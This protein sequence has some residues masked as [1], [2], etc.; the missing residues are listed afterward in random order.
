MSG[1]SSDARPLVVA[2]IGSG[3]RGLSVLERLAVRTAAEAER[4]PAG[5]VPR[6]VRIHLIDATEIGA[7]RVWRT[8]QDG[9]FTMNTVIS[10]V[11]M[12]SGGPD[13]GPARP[14]A[15]PSLGEWIERRARQGEEP[16]GP[17]D[18]ASRVRYGHYLAD[19]Y[20]T[21]VE[22]LPPH[23]RIVPVTGR[24][25]ALRT[26]TDSGYLLSLDTAPHLLEADRVVLA[27]GHPRNAPDAFEREM[28][29]FAARTPN[30]HY[31]CGDS[32]ADL[33]LDEATIPPGSAVGVRGLGLSFYDVMLSL[34]VGRGGTFRTENGELV[35]APSGREPEIVAGSRSGLPIPA[36][37]RNQKEPTYSHRSLFLTREALTAARAARAAGGG[38]GQL[39]F[40]EDVL[41]LLLREVEHVYYVTHVRTAQG[42]AAAEEF[43][44]SHADAVRRGDDR[45]PLLDAA[46]LGHVPPIDLN[47][48]ARPFADEE[49]DSP[50]A[51]RARLLDVMAEDLA[52]AALGTLDGPLKSALDVLRDI[53]NVVREAVDHGGLLPASHTGFFDRRF[54]PVNAL[55]SAGP[56]MV[57][58]EQLRALVR[59]G[60][61]TVVGPGTA[62]TSDARSGGYRVASAQVAGSARIVRALVDARIPTP[63]LPRDTSP[64]IRGLVAD[65]MA[66]PYV[67]EGPGDTSYTTG[68]MDVTASPFHVIDAA[69]EPQQD[70]YALG[71]P[72]EHTRWFTQVGS[73]RPGV[74]T[75][76]YR[77]ADAIAVDL[78]RPL[79]AG[80]R[81]GGQVLIPGQSTSGAV[82]AHGRRS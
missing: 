75:L 46:G 81:R 76:F 44:R 15:G 8:D 19:V 17:D 61:V 28:L 36:R 50:E 74:G 23:V 58:V 51:F 25:T 6:P 34:T 27:T 47:A 5:A 14:G 9:W 10:Q 54:L 59:Q 66:R 79:P 39:D 37:G 67:I 31:L 2:V 72:T 33:P 60:V 41:P 48:L 80:D 70:L 56:P 16:L 38:T 1:H 11:T 62:F 71:I 21:I 22:H 64:L 57:R 26:G 45:G 13:E 7:G 35:Y 20:R 68:G 49:F 65:G 53:R 40:A 78:L 4:L 69:G 55:L 82:A 29:D 52:Q 43:A 24:V 18:Y 3:P 30:T 73:S 77:D 32:A 12:Y 42:A 63:D